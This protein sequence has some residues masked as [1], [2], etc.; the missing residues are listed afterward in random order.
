MNIFKLIFCMFILATIVGC[1]IN[2]KP[3]WYSAAHTHTCNEEQMVR[4]QSETEWCND[5]T[6]LRSSYCYNS[7]IMR[8]CDKNVTEKTHED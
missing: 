7:A 2:E 6:T 5:N 8:V 3:E 1:D 4:V